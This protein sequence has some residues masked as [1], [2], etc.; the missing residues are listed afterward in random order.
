MSLNLH[1]MFRCYNLLK[2][3][4]H[5]NHLILENVVLIYHLH[6]LHQQLKNQLKLLLFQKPKQNR[7]SVLLYLLYAASQ[8]RERMSAGHENLQILRKARSFPVL[9]I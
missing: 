9:F 8:Q 4:H 6:L 3:H 5:L 1:Q 7:Y 2:I